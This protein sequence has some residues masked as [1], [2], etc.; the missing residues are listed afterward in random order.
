MTA[1][2]SISP[3]TVARFATVLGFDD[4]RDLKVFLQRHLRNT[5]MVSV[6]P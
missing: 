3:T 4:F 5:L 6:S 1:A 2:C